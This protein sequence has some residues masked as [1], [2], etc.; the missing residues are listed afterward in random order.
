LL[1]ASPSRRLVIVKAV[2]LYLTCLLYV[3][4]NEETTP[5]VWQTF[6]K[7]L[8][9]SLQHSSPDFISSSRKM[10]IKS[11]TFLV[12]LLFILFKN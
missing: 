11:P 9:N 12:R 5:R 3:I 7:L 10:Y 4:W 1:S 8:I 6:G 2:F